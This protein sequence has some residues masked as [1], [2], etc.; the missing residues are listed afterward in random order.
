MREA[1]HSGPD[2]GTVRAAR[3][4]DREAMDRLL[5]QCLPLVY[6]VVGRALNGHSDVDDL[7]QETLL[8]VVRGLPAL[9]DADAFRSWLVA[10]VVRQIRDR[11]Q[12]LAAAGRHRAEWE[13]AERLADPAADFVGLTVLRLGLTDQRKELAEATRW[14]DGDDRAL[15]ALWWL[16]ETGELSRAELAQALGVSRRHAAVRVQRMKEQMETARTVVRAVA[17]AGS[18]AGLGAVL[19]GWDGVPSPLWRKRAARH[20]RACTAC[21]GRGGLLPMER[22][23]AGLPLLPVPMGAG[24]WDLP[25]LAGLTAG[26]G[27]GGLPADPHGEAAPPSP[28]TFSPGAAPAAPPRTAP[29]SPRRSG[30]HR[31]GRRGAALRHPVASTATV[32][33]V[34]A[35][36]VIP[37]LLDGGGEEGATRVHSADARAV[38]S[39]PV[40]PSSAAPRTPSAR[41]SASPHRSHGPR[42]GKESAPPT[43]PGTPKPTAAPPV[44]AVTS[45]RKGVGVWAFPGADQALA[46][47][48][49]GWYYTWSSSP[50]GVVGAGARGFVP[51]V[52]GEKSVTSAD[53][54]LAKTNGP[55]LLGFNEPDMPGQADLSVDRALE[56]WPRLMSAGKVLGSPAV[57]YGGDTA[58]GWLDRFMTGAAS[59]GYR[60]DFVALHWYGGDFRTGP[61]V[62]QLKTYLEAVH[63]KYGK[64]VWLTEYALTD[65]SQ[66]VRLPS[67]SEQAAF[68]SAS[69]KM[70]D[71]LPYVRRYAWFGLPA[72]DE[73]PSTG[74]YRSGAVET[75][76]GRAFRTA[77]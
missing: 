72:A 12:A 65:F 13:S 4:G 22:L 54:A 55:Y 30:A 48:G 21:G 23:L 1:G 29:P 63:E 3:D 34:A 45:D 64:P 56:L 77:R 25:G 53:L 24:P 31:A 27:N 61:A 49:A 58:G 2:A 74:L 40:T 39:S 50:Q 10:I 32:A 14:L 44:R 9:R 70:L 57:A 42:T 6:N 36:L 19:H 68:L 46:R 66:G 18:C 38:P 20:V 76:V 43:R 37:F 67:E 75:T 60:V 8:R 62:Q 15:L 33:A 52:W 51:M 71:T 7:V 26:P 35:A 73:G 28:D 16:E 69:T 59:R 5:A 47:S 17:G 41:V 11:E